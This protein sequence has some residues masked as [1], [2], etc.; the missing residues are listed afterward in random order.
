MKNSCIRSPVTL[1][2]S[3][4]L[5]KRAPGRDADGRGLS[6][7]MM[8][9]P[10]LRDMPVIV[11]Q[12]IISCIEEVFACYGDLVVF[13]DLNMKINVLWVTVKPVTGICLELA[14]MIHH[15]IPES[16]LVAQKLS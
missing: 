13:A 8:I 5:W 2:L 3:E 10:G 9:I 16:R 4:P 7:F 15:A 1:S 14:A 11:Q 6:D 12:R